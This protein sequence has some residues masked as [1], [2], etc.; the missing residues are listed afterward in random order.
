MESVRSLMSEKEI[1]ESIE[2]LKSYLKNV[3]P[4]NEAVHTKI[5]HL[6]MQVEDKLDGKEAPSDLGESFKKY[7]DEF[8]ILHPQLSG[9]L[10][11]LI[12]SLSNM[13]I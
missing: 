10:K 2:N 4:Q 1:K 7:M 13:G 3:D 6:L 12:N 8:E 11:Q 9:N 5:D